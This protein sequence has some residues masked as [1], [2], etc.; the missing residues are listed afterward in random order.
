M[1]PRFQPALPVGQNFTVNFGSNSFNFDGRTITETSTRNFIAPAGDYTINQLNVS[2]RTTLEFANNGASP[3]NI[4]ISN[5]LTVR[6]NSTLIFNNSNVT[7]TGQINIEGNGRLIVQNGLLSSAVF[8]ANDDIR[9]DNQSQILMTD[10]AFNANG[11][12]LQ[13]RGRCDVKLGDGH[14]YFREISVR[15]N[16]NLE[17]GDGDLD[18]LRNVTLS[19]TASIDMGIGAKRIGGDLIS[20]QV[21]SVNI[22]GT[23][24]H[25]G[26][27]LNLSGTAQ[28]NISNTPEIFINGDFS[29][30]SISETPQTVTG[31]RFFIG[32]DVDILGS[33]RFVGTDVSFISGGRYNVGSIGEVNITSTTNNGAVDLDNIVFASLSSMPSNIGAT[34]AI[35]VEGHLYLPNSTLNINSLLVLVQ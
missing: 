13:I 4:T 5:T 23:S 31:S 10:T 9:V 28:L 20:T 15:E 32:G 18:V 7:V 25:I 34:A 14:K 35:T 19:G 24:L 26:G 3:N 30:T 17:L 12:I 33:S 16:S 29:L 1:R 2:G 8:T 6:D 22:P 27:S 21:S 11:G